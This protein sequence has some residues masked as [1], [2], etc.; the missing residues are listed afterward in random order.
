MS[1]TEE[2]TMIWREAGE[3][4][5]LREGESWGEREFGEV[6]LS[7]KRLEQRLKRLA[8]EFSQQPQAPINQASEDWAATKAAYRFFENPKASAK[9][10]FA[11]HRAKTVQRMAGQSVVLAIQDTTYLNYSHH[12]QTSGLGPIGDS[13]SD[14]QGLIMHGTLV[15]TPDGLP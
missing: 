6:E 5:R 14:A 12:P 1:V 10:I 3:E 13:R 7:D 15:V 2:G 9:K 4:G 8:N 11:A